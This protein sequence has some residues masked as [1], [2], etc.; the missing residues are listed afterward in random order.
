MDANTKRYY[1]A[2]S[3]ALLAAIGYALNSN[4][5]AVSYS[6]GA[7]PL[8]V[9]T[10][11]SIIGALGLF[12]L[13]KMKKVP[14][15]LPA[16]G[17]AAA[18]GMG[19]LFCL[20]A[21]SILSAFQFIPVALA[22]LIFYLFPLLTAIGAWT[23]YRQPLRPLFIAMLIVALAGLALALNTGAGDLDIRGVLW[24][25]ASSVVVAGFMLLNGKLVQGRDARPYALMILASAACMFVIASLIVGEFPLPG[26]RAGTAAFFGVAAAHATAFTVML[27]AV[28]MVG[29]VR[30]SLFLNFEPVATIILGALLLGQV[31]APLQLAGAAIVIA[32]VIIAGRQKI[33]EAATE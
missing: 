17:I 27:I 20:S 30:V 12:V 6:H 28:S 33:A 2:A 5:A 31:L 7:S 22:V 25:A 10:M 24:A 13:L 18:G 32:A 21:Y 19:V 14:L 9:L 11:R 23:F 26:S 8:S 4:L 15:K 29:P 16:I 1:W 3:L